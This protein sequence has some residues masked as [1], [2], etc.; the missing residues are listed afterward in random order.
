[1][2]INALR[3]LGKAVVDGS[4]QPDYYSIS[5]KDGAITEKQVTSQ[6]VMLVGSPEGGIT[7]RD[8][9]DDVKGK[10]C[11]SDEQ[12]MKLYEYGAAL[13]RHY[14]KPQDIEWAI[15]HD[16]KIYILQS[17]PLNIRTADSEPLKVP[18]HVEGHTVLLD[19]GIIA[20]KGMERL[21]Y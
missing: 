11:L 17:R 5:R 3:G 13:E 8:V 7:S 10:P 14:G 9:P 2:I 20:C 18:R 21:L 12:I 1:M 15:D 19:R 6:A 16:D 4:A